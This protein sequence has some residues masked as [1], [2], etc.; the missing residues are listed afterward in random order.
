M[1]TLLKPSAKIWILHSD[2]GLVRGIIMEKVTI[3]TL[4]E[5]CRDYIDLVS[6]SVISRGGKRVRLTSDIFNAEPLLNNVTE[7]NYDDQIILP[8]KLSTRLSDLSIE[9]EEADIESNVFVERDLAIARDLDDMYRKFETN[10]YT[11]QLSLQFGHI[12][13]KGIPNFGGDDE[14]FEESGHKHVEGYLFTVSI[15]L[16]YKDSGGQR[17][18]SVRIDDTLIKTN[19]GFVK[20]FMKL[21]YRDEL[22]KFVALDSNE[23]NSSIPISPGYIDELWT[24]ITTYLKFSDA[25]EISESPDLT[26][27]VIALEPKANYFLSQDLTGIIQTAGDGALRETSLSAWVDKDDHYI[28]EQIDDSGKHEIFFPF[29]YDKYQLQVLSKIN[30][31]GLIV[32]GPP[33]TGKSQTISN[34]LVHL[35]ATGKKVLFVS[36]KDQAVRGVKDKLKSLNIPCLFGYM[37]DRSSRLHSEE[38]ERDSAT[39]ALR[40]I[41]QSHLDSVTE[42]DPKS[43]LANISTK[44]PSFNLSIDESRTFVQTY[45][46]WRSLDEFDFGNSS[47][48]ITTEWYDKIQDLRKNVESIKRQITKQK[49]ELDGYNQNIES[50]EKDQEGVETKSQKVSQNFKETSHYLWLQNEQEYIRGIGYETLSNLTNAIINSFETTVL[51]RRV[52]ILSTKLNEFKLSKELDRTLH[53]LPFELYE[54]Y[55]S[56]IFLQNS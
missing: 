39:Y 9:S 4:A 15:V 37:P 36:Q 14:E 51:D 23:D 50:A 40:G 22:Y 54:T 52:N 41:S 44:V 55:K 16:D 18:Y 48:K 17:T 24:K 6:P 10:S 12:S 20:N 34:I 43:H 42:Q 3:K 26:D 7:I 33:G 35:A 2:I 25:I 56:I 8:I 38:D 13:F 29:S 31:K 47:T 28:T 53:Q 46:E 27:V 11:K 49:T 1:F 19:I 45:N 21:E 30:N 32:E 5:Y